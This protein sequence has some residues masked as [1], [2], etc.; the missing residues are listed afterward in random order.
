MVSPWTRPPADTFW[1]KGFL[2]TVERNSKPRPQKDPKETA[3][4]LRMESPMVRE[5]EPGPGRREERDES[6]GNFYI[7]NSSCSPSLHPP[8]VTTCPNLVQVVKGKPEEQG[9]L[10]VPSLRGYWNLCVS[11]FS[12]LPTFSLTL[13]NFPV[14]CWGW[15]SVTQPQLGSLSDALVLVEGGYTWTQTTSLAPQLPLGTLPE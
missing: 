11:Y 6:P 13:E 1:G 10:K 2:T 4:L 15:G 14:S 7:R 3:A 12:S 8:K 9:Q 5:A